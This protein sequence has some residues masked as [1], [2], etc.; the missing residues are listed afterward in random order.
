MVIPNSVT[1]I[2]N[3]AFNGC[4]GLTSITIGNSV[5]SIGDNVFNG[6]SG[7]TSITIPNTVTSIGNSAF[8]GCGGLTA[9][10]IPASVETIGGEA[11]K[12]CTGLN[13]MEI[14]NSVTSIGNGAFSGC[15][16]L[17]SVTLH[18]TA[19]G[20]WFRGMKSIEEV[21]FGEEVTIIGDNAFKGC[22]GLTAITNPNTVTSIGSSA[23][24][25]CGGLTAFTIPA[26]VQTIGSE[27]FK[28]CTGLTAMEI[29]NS[30]TSIGNSAFSGCS[31]M[32]FITIPNSVT[33]IGYGAFS[34]CSSLTSVNVNCTV[35]GNWF[36][37]L[38]SIKN[39]TF[40]NDV[41]TIGDNAFSRCS[42]LTAIIIPNSVTSIGSSAF[43]G[44][45]I[46]TEIVIPSAV[47]SIGSDAY[48]GCDGLRKLEFHCAEIDN[49]FSHNESIKEVVMGDEVTNIIGHSGSWSNSNGESGV[50]GGAFYG[51]TGLTT[52][53]IGKNV[54]N[55]GQRSFEKCS[56]LES[57]VIPANVITIDGDAFA[58][59][60][61]LE[62]INV[63][64]DNAIF[65]SRDNC[66][67]IIKTASNTLVVGCS[68]TVIPNDVKVIGSGA[69]KGCNKLITISVPASVTSIYNSA[70]EDCTAL[71]SFLIPS[72]VSSIWSDAFKGCDNIQ[73]V[74][75]NCNTVN[76][77]FKGITSITCLSFG[78][79]VTSIGNNAFQ[80]CTGLTTLTIPDKV[81]TLGDYAFWNC[82]NIATVE[83]GKGVTNIGT[84]AFNSCSG[85]TSVM[86]PKTVTTIGRNAFYGCDQLESV[87]V[88]QG[89]PIGITEDV[90]SNRTN[91]TLYVP[92]GSV[93]T[94]QAAAYWNEF[95]EIK[96]LFF[97]VMNDEQGVIYTANS[98]NATCYV[99]GHDDTYESSIIIPTTFQK[100]TVS[101]IGESAFAS[102]SSL[103]TI[104]IPSS[105]TSIGD[106]A[107]Y[108]CSNL[109]S[110]TVLATTPPS[111]TSGTFPDY[112][113]PVYVP[114]GCVEAYKNHDVWKYFTTI[115]EINGG[116]NNNT[117]EDIQ[118]TDVTNIDNVIYIEPMEE[119]KGSEVVV[120]ILMKNTADIRG[121][122]F[123][124]YLPNGVTVAK[125]SKGKYVCS[126]S[127]GRLP[128]DD[129][130]TLT[131]SEQEDGALRFL[132]GSQYNET[133]T[134]SE[135]EIATMK[136]LIAEDMAEGNYPIVLK[137][138]KLSETDISN[139]Y[140][141]ETVQTSLT[142]ISYT[143]GDISGDGEVDVS[144]YIGVANYI[145]GNAPEG[146]NAL[147]ADV[148]NDNVVDV[149]DY[150][151]VANLIL[152]GD[153]YGNTASNASRRQGV[154]KRVNTD[155]STMD[156]VIYVSP[157]QAGQ[158]AQVPISIKMKNTAE[159]RGFQFD[160]YLPDGISVVK[161][162]NDRIQG[163]LTNGRK[164]VGSQHT[165]TLS[166][167]PDG[168]IRF[169]CGSQYD[170]TFTGNDGEIAT[171]MVSIAADMAIDDY[172]ILL[173]KMKLS[174][175][176]IS[177][178]YET[179]LLET[180]ITVTEPTDDRVTFYETTEAAPE[181]ASG[182][183]VRVYRTIR[184]GEWSTICLPFA[185][186]EAQVK[187]AFGN[188]VKLG[189]FNGY[190]VTEDGDENIV[191]ISVKFNAVTEMAANHPYVM[192]VSSDITEFTVDG[193]DVS[194]TNKPTVT[195]GRGKM[196]GCYAAGTELDYGCL[197]LSNNK[198]CYS[199]GLTKI[200]AFRGYFDFRDYLTEFEQNY[201]QARIQMVFGDETVGEATILMDKGPWA[202]DNVVYDLQGRQVTKPVRKGV[203]VR[204]G[205]KV[206]LK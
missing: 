31:N 78:D 177:K 81:K 141:T 71:T 92:I 136:L 69:F 159:I 188:D 8:S 95:N 60:E 109:T 129:E 59:C 206:V 202:K 140:Y 77:W 96:G 146:F 58:Y 23:F 153:V 52:V 106:L 150:I 99:S 74:E 134:G 131:L 112:S 171:L 84:H 115:A 39:V 35:V 10:T 9:F 104:T 114:V 126:L 117:G 11:F 179:E 50:I 192:K 12:N 82:S 98:D 124:L 186:T 42:G 196:Y 14:P 105:V 30:V 21:T 123:D 166:Q 108:G 176:D 120:P 161:G 26:S 175:T 2:G 57:I 66:N 193:V 195:K 121:F 94:Y 200:Q 203:Y 102:C 63:S 70:F 191:G 170:E 90:F 4:E 133:F 198:F 28:D 154:V 86:I 137:K 56:S 47:V 204:S 142:V 15:N 18:S 156:N 85:I 164:P 5:T 127:N 157:F 128:E 25:G 76:D 33:S 149:S 87:A 194:P 32:T 83:I 44:C 93:E 197:F 40:G 51:C 45:I 101:S 178:Y 54:T 61:S 143:L 180:T 189:D 38:E 65:D 201:S 205:R 29:P 155:V 168:A 160:L 163:F 147:A 181:A 122:Q 148:N 67:A 22:S 53:T 20:S 130:H 49:W 80:G 116:G 16:G 139:Y 169:L 46:P 182:V 190:N 145:L 62:S 27:A 187:A 13:A 135:G 24:S 89:T 79:N 174:E 55:I 73:T 165:L 107:F 184:A 158:G 113:A 7:L 37:G 1:S 152:Y 125:T 48:K 6:C 172:P 88:E 19:V 111:I 199:V 91:A 162:P 110:I 132:C 34:G 167:Q 183:D 119:T 97:G 68:N 17:T 64:K 75:I 173:K 118:C 100:R 3:N 72:S 144:D 36:S 43:Q 41:K 185:M 138:V 151:G 103:T